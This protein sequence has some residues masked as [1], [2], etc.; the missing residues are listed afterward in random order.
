MLVPTERND[1][2]AGHD[3]SAA[4][5]E[6]AR[7]VQL[8][9]DKEHIRE[10]IYRNARGVDRAD[11]EL[12]K[13]TYHPDGFEVHWETFTGNGRDFADFISKEV[14]AARSVL[15]AISNALIDVQGDRAFSESAYTARTIVDRSPEL[16][17]AV[18]VVVWGRY[19][20]VLARRNGV[21]RIEHRQLARDG[22]KRN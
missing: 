7:R 20:D 18:E 3:A 21:W 12:L 1:L 2:V 5:D 6:L 17:G 9:E 13:G 8:L 14:P 22:V 16:G 4:L 19:L 11:A 15:H 10:V